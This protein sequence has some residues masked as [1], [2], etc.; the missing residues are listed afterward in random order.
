MWSEPY[1]ETCCRAALHRLKLS[2]DL[3]RPD[4]LKDGPCLHRVAAM[5][6]AEWREERFVLT[7][8]GQRRHASEIGRRGPGA[9]KDNRG[10]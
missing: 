5:G 9:A 7:E 10:P 2:G 8:P 3:G 6:L 4:G 1:L